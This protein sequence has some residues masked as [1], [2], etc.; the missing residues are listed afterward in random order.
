MNAKELFWGS[1]G[2]MDFIFHCRFKSI[3]A[4][5]L[6]PVI[7]WLIGLRFGIGCYLALLLIAF[8]WRFYYLAFID[9]KRKIYVDEYIPNSVDRFSYS[10]AAILTTGLVVIFSI[11]QIYAPEL[12]TWGNV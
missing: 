4:N 8:L 6:L 9:R 12:M 11:G 2:R 7:A 10:I 1:I 5:I 3:A